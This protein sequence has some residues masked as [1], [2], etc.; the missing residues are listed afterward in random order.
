M[1]H[2]ALDFFVEAEIEGTWVCLITI[3]Q[4][5]AKN[6]VNY[7]ITCEKLTKRDEDIPYKNRRTA[8]KM[9]IEKYDSER[10]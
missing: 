8:S 6:S 5:K 1:Y 9:R 10:N 7:C 4:N 3:R 2:A